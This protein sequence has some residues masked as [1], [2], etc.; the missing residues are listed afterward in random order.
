MITLVIVNVIGVRKINNLG[1]NMKLIKKAFI[2]ENDHEIKE[3]IKLLK[4]M[5]KCKVSLVRSLSN[6][7][8][9]H[10]GKP[11]IPDYDFGYTKNI[12]LR[13]NKDKN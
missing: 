5:R 8:V 11:S 7:F 1:N 3:F 9:L 10:N 12:L 6:E 4:E 2:F 13:N